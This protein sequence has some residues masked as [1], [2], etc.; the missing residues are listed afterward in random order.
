MTRN[1][2]YGT[3]S[4]FTNDRS[5]ETSKNREKLSVSIAIYPHLLSWFAICLG[6]TQTTIGSG[7]TFVLSFSC[8][9][10]REPR[11]LYINRLHP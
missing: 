2:Y 3:R 5:W 7:K 11:L 6:W 1:M 4:C 9:Y 8:P 10:L